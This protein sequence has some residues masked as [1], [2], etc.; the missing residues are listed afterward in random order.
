M[1][2]NI[3]AKYEAIAH[4]GEVGEFTLGNLLSFS[5]K[6]LLFFYPKDNTPGC[7]VENK[8]FSCLVEDF[9]KL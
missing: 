9:T 5:E 2:V 7:T 3:N 6:T 1:S 4:T 8:D